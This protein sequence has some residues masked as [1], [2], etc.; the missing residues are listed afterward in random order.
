[1]HVVVSTTHS[2][3]QSQDH[4][5]RVIAL[6]NNEVRT[7]H[8]SPP[9]VHNTRAHATG[10]QS[11]TCNR[12]QSSVLAPLCPVYT[13]YV[14]DPAGRVYTVYIW[15]ARLNWE[16]KHQYTYQYTTGSELM[17]VQTYHTTGE[18][19]D[20]LIKIVQVRGDKTYSGGSESFITFEV[21]TSLGY[22]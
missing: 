16:L 14:S 9:V 17:L 11:T 15:L 22:S 21:C 12:V 8:M 1:M 5:T 3:R 2:T 20:L 19:C 6:W 13:L 4:S 18:W 10:R 7:Y